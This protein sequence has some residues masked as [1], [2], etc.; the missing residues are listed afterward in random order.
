[1]HYKVVFLVTQMSWKQQAQVMRA[2]ALKKYECHRLTKGEPKGESIIIVAIREGLG[3]TDKV[4]SIMM[5]GEEQ[6]PEDGGG[7][8]IIEETWKPRVVC[9][10]FNVHDAQL[11]FK[12]GTSC[13]PSGYIPVPFA[14]SCSFLR[15]IL[16]S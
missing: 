14:P 6:G 3:A 5:A 16:P 4:V 2:A 11:Y 15:S 7:G 10:V 13:G 9:L 8:E 1:M 12:S